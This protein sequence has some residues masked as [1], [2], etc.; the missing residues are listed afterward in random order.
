MRKTI[1]RFTVGGVAA[2][3]LLV[4]VPASP[5]FA[6]NQVD[7]GQRTDLVKLDQ[8]LGGGLIANACFANA[9]VTAV[10]VSGVYNITSGN[11]KVTVNYQQGSVYRSVTLDPRQGFGLVGGTARVYEVRIW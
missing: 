3:G 4:A 8:S 7:C 1:K 11:N 10:N 6:I 2:L 5:A 9:G